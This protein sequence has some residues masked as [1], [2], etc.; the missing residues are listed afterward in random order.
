M[1]AG[2]IELK[3]YVPPETGERFGAGLFEACRPV[4]T[5]SVYYDTTDKRLRAKGLELRVRTRDGRHRQTI[6]AKLDGS[7][8]EREEIETDLGCDA[9]DPGLL[10]KTASGRDLKPNQLALEP[11]FETR[12]ARTRRTIDCPHLDNARIEVCYD[13]GQ[14]CANGDSAPVSEL[15]L[16]LKQGDVQ[17]LYAYGLELLEHYAFTLSLD[18]KADRGYRLVLREDPGCF[19]PKKLGLPGSSDLRQGIVQSLRSAFAHFL[20]NHTAFVATGEPETIHQMRVGL[21]RFRSAVYAFKPVLDLAGAEDLLADAKSLFSDLGEIREIDV[22]L[23]DVLPETGDLLTSDER[24]TLISF[25]Q[26][27][28]ARHYQRQRAFVDSPDF[29]R[30]VL[31]LGMWIESEDWM[32]REAVYGQPLSAFARTRLQSLHRK[33]LKQA[34]GQKKDDFSQWHEL[35][36]LTKKLRYTS[37]FFANQ[38]TRS[39]TRDYIREL[40]GWQDRL[41]R[42]NDL[43]TSAEFVARLPARAPRGK[44]APLERVALVFRGW[45]QAKSQTEQQDLRALWSRF[46]HADVFWEM[47]KPKAKERKN[48]KRSDKKDRA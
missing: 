1:S 15:E 34:R 33:L 11:V 22:F 41:G 8:F 28:R 36:I 6:K 20:H 21:R 25:L 3:F 37:E 13:V 5:T 45:S 19:K 43:A 44:K 48:K 35:R 27:L 9:P 46:E 24:E 29:A 26:D 16:E 10:R 18:G 38:F 2:E 12:M 30:F 47:D 4:R 14:I 7:A 31:R 32:R 39:K 42:L 23:A 17:A 40:S